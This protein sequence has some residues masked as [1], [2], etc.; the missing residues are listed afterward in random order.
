MA[1]VSKFSKFISSLNH[2]P[3]G[4]SSWILNRHVRRHNPFALTTGIR[5]VSLNRR[6]CITQI[7]STHKVHGVHGGIHQYAIALAAEIASEYLLKVNGPEGLTYQLVDSMLKPT[8]L[9]NGA[10]R[11]YARISDESVLQLHK[12]GQGS[13]QLFLHIED[14]EGRN[15][16]SCDMTWGWEASKSLSYA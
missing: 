16:L 12:Q 10:V 13:T 3:N 14:A 7:R 11:V 6:E 2:L 4:L 5:I 1:H 8:N 9:S 15:P